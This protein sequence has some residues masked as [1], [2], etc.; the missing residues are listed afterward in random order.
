M[1]V[2]TGVKVDA[3]LYIKGSG[4]VLFPIPFQ[5]MHIPQDISQEACGVLWEVNDD[6]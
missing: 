4:Y 5:E 3:S 2:C 1:I 6:I